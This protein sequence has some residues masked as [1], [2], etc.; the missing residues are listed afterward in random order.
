MDYYIRLESLHKP[1]ALRRIEKVDGVQAVIAHGNASGDPRDGVA[2][3]TKRVCPEQPGGA[4]HQPSCHASA[5]I[6]ALIWST[7]SHWSLESD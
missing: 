7:V 3:A 6:M 4:S 2:E 1:C 5:P